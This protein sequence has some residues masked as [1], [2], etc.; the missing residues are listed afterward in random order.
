VPTAAPTAYS[1]TTRD[2]RTIQFSSQLTYE[3]AAAILETLPGKFEQRLAE[4]YDGR[5]WKGKQADWGLYLAEQGKRQPIA[6]KPLKPVYA[7]G[8]CHQCTGPCH[9]DRE[10]CRTCSGT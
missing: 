1:V 3:E 6:L 7:R 9:P 10:I 8:T 4:A 5:G 2:G